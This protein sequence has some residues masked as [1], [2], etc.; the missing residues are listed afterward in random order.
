M[1]FNQIMIALAERGKVHVPTTDPRNARE[2]IN[3]LAAEDGVSVRIDTVA[4]GV[5]VRLRR[6]A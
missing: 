5:D 4:G 3:I 2:T 1:T 6:F